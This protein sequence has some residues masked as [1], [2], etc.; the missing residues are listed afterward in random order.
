MTAVKNTTEGEEFLIADSMSFSGMKGLC[1]RHYIVVVIQ[2]NKNVL[3][4]CCLTAS[5]FPEKMSPVKA[6]TMKDYENVSDL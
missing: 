4:P 2:M 1:Q 6:L 3:M 5:S